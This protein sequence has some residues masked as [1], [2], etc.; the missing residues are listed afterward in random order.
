MCFS[1]SNLIS[2]CA[3]CLWPQNL[4]NSDPVHSHP[5]PEPTLRYW[6]NM[7]LPLSSVLWQQPYF[8]VNLCSVRVIPLTFL[9]PS[10]FVPKPSSFPSSS[11]NL[12][13][14]LSKPPSFLLSVGL[15]SLSIPSF[16][17][18]TLTVWFSE[19]MKGSVSL[20]LCEAESGRCNYDGWSNFQRRLSPRG[21]SP[22]CFL[23][24]LM[25]F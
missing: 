25:T 20:G 3:V 1:K 7:S 5:A 2:S 14:L 8:T 24:A 10:F 16:P 6:G 15:V 11:S 4:K 17:P 9:L 21:L 12:L 23:S 13:I 19:V 18:Y 22:P